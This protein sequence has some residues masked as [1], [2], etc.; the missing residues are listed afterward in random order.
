MQPGVRRCAVL[1]SPIEHSLSPVLHTAAYEHLGLTGWEYGRHEVTESTLGPFLD[2]LDGSWR[3]LSLTMP[4]KYAALSCADEVSP[5]AR[6]VSA[7]NTMLIEDDGRRHADN[8]DVPG[9]VN[10]LREHGVGSV[11]EAVLLGAGATGRCALASLRDLT[12]RVVAFL[13]TPARA[14]ELQR[15]ADAVG[16]ALETRP[17]TDRRD[18][19]AAPLVITTVPVG[20]VDDLETS[21]PSRP[22]VLLDVVYA[23]WP[24]V[25]ADAWLSAGGAVIGGLDFL[26]HQARLQ[27]TLM[28]GREVPVRVLRAAGTAALAARSSHRS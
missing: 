24:T 14:S 15:V 28:T 17:W 13:R 6:V 27:V 2:G 1:G 19:L 16:I 22:G 21:V 7:A 10:A 8:T 18:A 23:P 20:V 26:V 4:L 11:T 9:M 5:L 12:R 25:L 3:G